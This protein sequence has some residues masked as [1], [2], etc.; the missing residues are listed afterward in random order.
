MEH[1]SE[2]DWTGSPVLGPLPERR[3][4]EE[5]ISWAMHLTQHE[6]EQDMRRRWLEFHLDHQGSRCAYCG[7]EIQIFRKD[8]NAD[9][10]ATVDHITPLSKGGADLVENTLGACRR[11]NLAKGSID[12][13]DFLIGPEFQRSVCENHPCPDRIYGDPASPYFNLEA[14]R[15]GVRIW[16]NGTEYR[17]VY[18]YCVSEGVAEI[19]VG[20]TRT[21]E[22]KRM[23]LKK[24]GEIRPLF[25]DVVQALERIEAGQFREELLAWLAMRE[26]PHAVRVRNPTLP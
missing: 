7:V 26:I 9:L 4:V 2:T 15:R 19:V 5:E 23:T 13:D 24:R 1:M 14:L 10:R 8:A 22:G 3:A 16:I 12:L 11:C 6:T 18:A 21:R 25:R 17:S 20:K